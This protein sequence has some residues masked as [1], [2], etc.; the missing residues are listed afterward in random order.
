MKRVKAYTIMELT[1]GMLIAAL[2]IT[3][4]YT[5]FNIVALSFSEFTKKHDHLASLLRLDEL[6]RRDMRI[7][8]DLRGNGNDLYMFVDTSIVHYSFVPKQVIRHALRTD[9]FDVNTDHVEMRFEKQLL[10]SEYSNGDSLNRID[11]LSF[12]INDSKQ[13]VPYHYHKI[14]SAVNL[15]NNQHASY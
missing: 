14:Y 3:M 5:V 13:T 2:V 8:N 7:S 1:V 11:E 10:Q 4:A 6:L 15:I 9:T 12:M